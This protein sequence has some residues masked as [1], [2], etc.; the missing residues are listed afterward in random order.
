GLQNTFPVPAHALSDCSLP[1]FFKLSI[2]STENTYDFATLHALLLSL[3]YLCATFSLIIDVTPE[4]VNFY[5]GTQS[6][7]TTDCAT[8]LVEASLDHKLTSL[9]S[10]C[11]LHDEIC[12]ITSLTFIPDLTQISSSPFST[13]LNTIKHQCVTLFFLA[14]PLCATTYYQDSSEV[15]SLITALTPFRNYEC[16]THHH[17]TDSS[18]NTSTHNTNKNQSSSCTEG[19]TTTAVNNCSASC[20]Q[21]LTLNTTKLELLGINQNNNGTTSKGNSDTLNKNCSSTHGNQFTESDTCTQTTGLTSLAINTTR[22]QNENRRAID[23]LTQGTQVNTYYQNTLKLPLYT[24]NTFF[25]ACDLPTTLFAAS[26]FSNL[27]PA[28]SLYN[29]FIN[30]WTHGCPGFK[31]MRDHLLCLQLPHFHFSPKDK[32]TFPLGLPVTTS[33]LATFLTAL[34]APSTKQ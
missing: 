27:F 34:L 9:Y 8:L 15:E 25:T 31:G 18:S 13:F 33:S 5:I 16:T 17:C 29:S 19:E 24:L 4:Q 12:A 7:P 6:Y 3:Y 1:Y 32:C 11:F 26:N 23:L 20:T 10:P 28:T 30:N 2:P 21:A 14:T 22:Y